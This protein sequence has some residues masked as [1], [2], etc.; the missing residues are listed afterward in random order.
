MEQIRNTKKR[1]K[2]GRQPNKLDK[3][4]VKEFKEEINRSICKENISKSL[5]IYKHCS[6]ELNFSFVYSTK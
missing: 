3:R 4:N 6:Y 1:G 5:V 2:E